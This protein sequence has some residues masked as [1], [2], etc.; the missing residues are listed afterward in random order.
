MNNIYSNSKKYSELSKISTTIDD[1]DTLVVKSSPE[2][3]KIKV[4]KPNLAKF[5]DPVND[6]HES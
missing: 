2:V 1:A 6:Q 5:R 4:R 3:I